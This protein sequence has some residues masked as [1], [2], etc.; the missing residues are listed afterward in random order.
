MTPVWLYRLQQAFV[1]IV[2]FVLLGW[3][4]YT[5]QNAGG[6]DT[7]TVM[8]HFT[9]MSIL[10]AVLIRG[11]A[12]WAKRHHLNEIKAKRRRGRDDHK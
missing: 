6:M 9:G 5:L 3:I 8:I 4:W 10:G 11:T 7:Q 12:W 2:H 1:T